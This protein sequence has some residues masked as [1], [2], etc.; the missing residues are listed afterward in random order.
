MKPCVCVSASM[1]VLGGACVSICVWLMLDDVL[2]WFKELH[3]YCRDTKPRKK[4]WRK[5]SQRANFL[6][7]FFFFFGV[8]ETSFWMKLHLFPISF[9]NLHFPLILQGTKSK[10]EGR[11]WTFDGRL[12]QKLHV[13]GAVWGLIIFNWTRQDEC[14]EGSCEQEHSKWK[15]ER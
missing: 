7:W 13:L 15:E 14:F 8:I 11:K 3:F 1:H 2:N 5:L 6:R 12:G 4:W 10:R 9:F